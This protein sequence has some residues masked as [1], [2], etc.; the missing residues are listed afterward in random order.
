MYKELLIFHIFS[1]SNIPTDYKYTIFN[2]N[3]CRKKT[4][5]MEIW[6]YYVI[7]IITT[8]NLCNIIKFQLYFNNHLFHIKYEERNLY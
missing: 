3:I 7:K 4:N 1:I 6:K 8:E 5:K 2:N